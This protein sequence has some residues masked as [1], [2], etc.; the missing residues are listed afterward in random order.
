MIEHGEL[1]LLAA[2][3]TEVRAAHERLHAAVAGLGDDELRRDTRLPGWTVAHVLVHLARNAD[4][5]VRRLAAAAEGR[6]V[7]QY[8]GGAAERAAEIEAG[9]QRGAGEV[10][11]DLWAADDAVDRVFAAADSS[12][13]AG[14]VQVGGGGTGPAAALVFRRWREV[15]VH[16]V[17]LGVGH[18]WAQWPEALVARWLPE[19]LT[20]LP[21][22]ADPRALVAW[23]IGRGPAPELPPWA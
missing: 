16:H 23:T 4:S 13:W 1:P 12:S 15:E 9:V 8:P 20:A 22:R 18:S 3:V 10:L 6:V 14:T 21:D 5:I 11:A 19:L 7:E 17:D 2:E